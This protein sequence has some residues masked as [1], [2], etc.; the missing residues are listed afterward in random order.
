LKPS[1]GFRLFAFVFLFLGSG[2]LGVAVYSRQGDERA[3]SL[4]LGGIGLVFLVAGL[5][6]FLLPARFEFDRSTSLFHYQ[7]PFLRLSCPVTQIVAI[8]LLNGGWHGGK[9]PNSPVY[10]TYQVNLVLRD[11][12]RPRLLLTNHNHWDAS[13]ELAATLAEF[14]GVPLLDEVSEQ[15]EGGRQQFA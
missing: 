6:L 1:L 13:W 2:L 12:A 8:Q 15:D 5:L 7:R 10:F 11:E 3:I 14:L 4:I 9:N